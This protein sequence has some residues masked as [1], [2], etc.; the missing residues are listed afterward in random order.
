V[1]LVEWLVK[2][3]FA[4]VVILG[5]MAGRARHGEDLADTP[6]RYICSQHVAHNDKVVFG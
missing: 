1:R 3:Q 6:L 5:S 2:Q 4:R